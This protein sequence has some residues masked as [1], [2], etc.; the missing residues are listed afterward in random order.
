MKKL[1]LSS[2]MLLGVNST[3]AQMNFN[4]QALSHLP[5]QPVAINAEQVS[6]TAQ[7]K[8]ISFISK[9]AKVQTPVM[10]YR[11]PA[12]EGT[13]H[14]E[15]ESEADK[16]GIF[17]PSV[18]V[19]DQEFH[20]VARYPSERFSFKPASGF[21]EDRMVLDF[22]LTPASAQDAMYIMLYTT[23]ATLA[24]TTVAPHPAKRYAIATGTQPPAIADIR[25]AHKLQG[26]ITL[27]V[28]KNDDTNIVGLISQ[29]WLG[30]AKPA[31]VIQA[32]PVKKTQKAVEKTT[33]QY[34]N[35]A[36]KRALKAGDINRALNLVNEAE[37]LG[38]TEPRQIFIQQLKNK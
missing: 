7:F 10:L 23:Q 3:F 34:F 22:N 38:L 15:I 26:K 14:I 37:L 17:A 36:I 13:L 28:E 11:L 12:N 2:L 30:K 27:N 4:A 35:Q 33:Q 16:K 29:N 25:L 20:L 19:F 6:D 9:L 1:M 5:W 21:K 18:M 31:T 8:P 32:Q 24:E